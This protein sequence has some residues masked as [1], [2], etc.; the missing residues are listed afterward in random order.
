MVA[1]V[2]VITA[3]LNSLMALYGDF[4]FLQWYTYGAMALVSIICL[5][6]TAILLATYK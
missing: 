3:I 1:I 5:M 2:Q 4:N 6:Q